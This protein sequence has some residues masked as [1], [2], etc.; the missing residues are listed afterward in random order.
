MFSCQIDPANFRLLFVTADC[1]SYHVLRIDK[2]GILI[3][4]IY[5]V[6]ALSSNGPQN[7]IRRAKQIRKNC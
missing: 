1:T 2:K 7:W 6:G 5:I 3:N 4:Q